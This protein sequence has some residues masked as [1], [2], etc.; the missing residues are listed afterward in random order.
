MGLVNSGPNES[1]K[2]M[3]LEEK[4]ARADPYYCEL[5]FII[6]LKQLT[7]NSNHEFYSFRR[8]RRNIISAF[9]H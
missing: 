3:K 7:K 4:N 1:F 8:T 5:R 9:F 6:F 2:I